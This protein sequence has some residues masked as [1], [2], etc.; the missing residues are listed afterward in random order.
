MS[1]LACFT[2]HVQPAEGLRSVVLASA[3]RT[4]DS[5]QRVRTLVAQYEFPD[6]PAGWMAAFDE[7]SGVYYYYNEYTGQ[8]QWEPPPPLQESMGCQRFSVPQQDHFGYDHES[9]QQHSQPQEEAPP[10]AADLVRDSR[11][12]SRS[13]ARRQHRQAQRFADACERAPAKLDLYGYALPAQQHTLPMGSMTSRGSAARSWEAL[14]ID[15]LTTDQDWSGLRLFAE[16]AGVSAGARQRAN[17][18]LAAQYRYGYVRS[19][20]YGGTQQQVA[21]REPPHAVGYCP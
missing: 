15:D 10:I 21:T 11:S 2:A 16:L 18:L 8:S 12:I 1:T 20:Q 14:A 19:S 6:L 17:D 4:I 13:V 5:C 9:W 3:P 7:G